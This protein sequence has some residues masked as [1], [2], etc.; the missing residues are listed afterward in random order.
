MRVWGFFASF[1]IRAP[2]GVDRETVWSVPNR[3]TSSP[4]H[5]EAKMLRRLSD[6]FGNGPVIE[7]ANGQKH[8]PHIGAG[9]RGV[10]VLYHIQGRLHFLVH[11]S[12][13]AF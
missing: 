3:D 8:T 2:V 13:R 7:Q 1:L 9:A 10:K 11:S 12:S 5:N 6:A 4:P